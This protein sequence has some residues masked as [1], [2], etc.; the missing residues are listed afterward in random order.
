MKRRCTMNVIL[1]AFVLVISVG[2][3]FISKTISKKLVLIASIYL[4]LYKAVEYTIYGLNLELSKIPVEYSTITYFLLSITVIFEIKQI[5][6]LAAFMGFIS[7]LGYVIVFIFLGSSYYEHQGLFTTNMAF[8]NHSIIFIISLLLMRDVKFHLVDKKKI[9]LFTTISIVY[10]IFITRFITFTQDYIFILMLLG[11]DLL[12]LII[13]K[14]Y[15]SSY[16]YLIY[17]LSLLIL[18][19]VVI[20][21]FIVIN[22]L[23]N[24]TR[25][26]EPH[27]HSV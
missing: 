8:I 22:H 25:Q 17:F 26:G 15:I 1:S 20:H 4:F 7:G 6:P 11:G 16:D 3:L 14:G 23:L 27:E 13:P 2:L 12:K 10:V 19:Q 18:Y 24:R 9:F 21:L 5:K